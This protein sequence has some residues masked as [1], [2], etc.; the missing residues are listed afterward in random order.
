MGLTLS[1]ADLELIRVALIKKLCLSEDASTTTIANAVEK[2]RD[3]IGPDEHLI[4]LPGRSSIRRYLEGKAISASALSQI[5]NFLGIALH[6]GGPVSKEITPCF[7]VLADYESSGG[8]TGICIEPNFLLLRSGKDIYLA[9]VGNK[10]AGLSFPILANQIGVNDIDL[11]PEDRIVTVGFSRSCVHPVFSDP[12]N[13]IKGILVDEAIEFLNRTVPSTPIT[14]PKASS[15]FP[16]LQVNARN[17]MRML[18]KLHGDKV[19]VVQATAVLSKKSRTIRDAIEEMPKY[20]RFAPSPTANGLHLGN[21]RTALLNSWIY[22]KDPARNRCYLRFDD[23]R[24]YAAQD[25]GQ[26][27]QTMEEQL[28]KTLGFTF[29]AKFS[30]SDP[31]R[32]KTYEHFITL[33]LAQGYARRE[34]NGDVYFAFQHPDLGDAKYYTMQWGSQS[35][36]WSSKVRIKKSEGPHDD[37]DGSVS[38]THETTLTEDQIKESSLIFSGRDR[39]YRYKFAGTV[40][41]LLFATVVVR[42][43]QQ[44]EKGFTLRQA[45]IAEAILKSFAALE[46]EERQRFEDEL[47]S[48]FPEG[49]VSK[50][51][52]LSQPVYC[53]AAIM[54]NPEAEQEHLDESGEKKSVPL[55]KSSPY[56]ANYTIQHLRR[57]RRYSGDSILLYALSTIPYANRLISQLGGM[58]YASKFV[59]T[60]G[61]WPFLDV[62]SDAT[63][64]GD[65]ADPYKYRLVE[66]NLSAL[67]WVDRSI[68]LNSDFG[69]M[70]RYMIQWADLLGVDHPS[71]KWL[72][73]LYALRASFSGWSEA[74]DAMLMERSKSISIKKQDLRSIRK[75]LTGKEQGPKVSALL[76]LHSITQ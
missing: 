37:E 75:C 76:N 63:K 61:I 20:T 73:L 72:R 43:F 11:E 74:I 3:T 15:G 13:R 51:L 23:T 28:E 56:G 31:N 2:V 35:A 47:R 25:T 26:N 18:R 8:A 55:S 29:Q 33:L 24:S 45:I 62:L 44:Y 59:A 48:L 70:K 6:Q 69:R 64:L 32:V 46:S 27:K 22:R 19:K 1:T 10:D 5:L 66:P 71:E 39:R 16:K 67:E 52:I 30:Q 41:D 40:D 58:R 57:D 12:H 21:I 36:V 53:Y 14:V 60:F 50:D 4:V 54:T 42:D 49:T 17:F 9:I 65:C 38:G 7:E 34:A 68:W